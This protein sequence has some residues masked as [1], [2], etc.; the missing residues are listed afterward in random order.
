MPECYVCLAEAETETGCACR[1]AG[2]PLTA[3]VECLARFARERGP[4]GPQWDTCPVC[5]VRYASGEIRV[6]LAD[7]AFALVRGLPAR[8]A[9]KLRAALAC[10]VAR[11]QR[12]EPERAEP[13]LRVVVAVSSGEGTPEHRALELDAKH[14]LAV[15]MRMLGKYDEALPLFEEVLA[16]EDLGAPDTQAMST[17]VSYAYAL[18]GDGQVERALPIMRLAL[19]TLREQTGPESEESISAMCNLAQG[20]ALRGHLPEAEAILREAV[21]LKRRVFGATHAL[22]R[23]SELDLALVEAM[24]KRRV[25][26][27]RLAVPPLTLKP[28]AK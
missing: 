23:T 7:S 21:A 25:R 5:H 11:N 18:C 28:K 15:T 9:T 1:H 3:H 4:V 6:A 27:A 8:D 20:V 12:N 24:Q 26:A 19:A 17:A 13:L 22:T 16:L 14:A 10:G 2:A